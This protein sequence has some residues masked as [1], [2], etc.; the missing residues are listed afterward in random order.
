MLSD[1]VKQNL[2]EQAKQRL[3]Q[4]LETYLQRLAE[5]PAEITLGQV[6]SALE[7]IGRASCQPLVAYWSQDM[8]DQSALVDPHCGHPL[9]VQS[10]REKRTFRS[11]C[12]SVTVNR[13]Y[14]W[15]PHCK[16]WIFPADERLGL[17]RGAQSPRLQEAA[18]LSV[19][20]MPAGQ[21]EEVCQRVS[22]LG[23]SRATLA[24]EAHRQGLRA[25]ELRDQQACLAQ[26]SQ[27]VK[28]LAAQA[29]PTLPNQP[30]TLVIQMDAFNIR[31]RD[32]W[33][34]TEKMRRAG[35]EISRWHWVFTGTCFRLDQRGQTAAGRP[36]ISDRG[37]VATRMGL[38]DFEQQLFA[39]AL[40]RGLLQAQRVLVIG[41]GAIW[42]W[43][44]AQNSFPQAAQR[45][46]LWHIKEH[47]W[48][49]AND[50]FGQ[51][52]EDARAWV[53]PLFKMLE[54]QAD[55]A[56]KVIHSL[57]ELKATI[58]AS[59]KQVIQNIQKQIDY[60]KNH[61]N[62]M[63]YPAG[64]NKGEPVGSGAIESTCKQYQCRFKR[65]GQFWSIAGDE[66]LLSLETTH[67]NNRWHLL[68]P[69]GKFSLSPLRH[70]N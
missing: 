19:L 50:L 20:K 52:S 26:T 53:H 15:C 29:A 67:R 38:A 11:L 57:E 21:A 55:G 42:I 5:A 13:S 7:A 63:D 2:I 43:N 37:F 17:N 64:K 47:L 1:T 54:S 3:T 58:R 39:E 24:R 18:A 9:V 69:P 30:F 45:I 66:A 61:Q 28:R 23:M 36:I 27:G 14:G 49:V 31:E 46:D 16:K 62:R 41:D 70:L 65:T 10:H 35:E 68:F 33:G 6:E 34:E 59:Q 48:A 25:Q 4:A 32:H 12:G 60:F 51:D 8:A 44:V 22:R 40:L 56:L